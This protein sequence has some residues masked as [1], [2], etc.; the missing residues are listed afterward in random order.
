MCSRSRP[1]P[2]KQSHVAP[3]TWAGQSSHPWLLLPRNTFDPTQTDFL[4]Q[5]IVSTLVSAAMFTTFTVQPLLRGVHLDDASVAAESSSR[6]LLDRPSTGNIPGSVSPTKSPGIFNR[7]TRPVVESLDSFGE[8]RYMSA[9]SP[10]G[11]VCPSILC[12]DVSTLLLITLLQRITSTWA[13][14]MDSCFTI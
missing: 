11:R 1:Y 3:P 2:F 8:C 4:R 7:N 12:V 13:R 9:H 10:Y 14:P 6:S 5:P